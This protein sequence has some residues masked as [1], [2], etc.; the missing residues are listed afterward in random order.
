MKTARRVSIVCAVIFIGISLLSTSG[1]TA[2]FAA[3]KEM[4]AAAIKEGEVSWLDAIVVPSSAKAIAE[5]FKKEYGLPDT[6]NVKHERLASGPIATRVAEEVKANR[7][8]IDLFAAPVPTLYFDLKEYGALLRYDCPE[9]KNFSRATK[10]GLFNEPGYWQSAIAQVFA[11]VTNPKIYPKKI[12]SWNDLLSPDL[13]GGKITLPAIA[14]GGG[15]LYC[16]VG[17][18]KVLSKGYFQDMYKQKVAFDRG[19]SVDATQQLTQ[20]QILVAITSAFRI[21]QTGEQTGVE[22]TAHYPKEGV[23]LLGHPYGILAK[24][25]HPNAAK[26]LV[27]FLFSEK[28]N[29]LFIEQEGVIA[30]RDGM[31]VPEKI[32]KYSPP[33][34]E[35]V[36][37]PMDWKSL[38]SKTLNQFLEEFKEIFK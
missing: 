27:D 12:A 19:S 6:F 3:S 18:R 1:P 23:S 14:N 29:R 25:P 9:Y 33:L 30:V 17:W 38:D 24:A 28:G 7:V 10:V 16:Y 21:V 4:I 34:E 8:T 37:I 5:A 32:R 11:P 22:L 13:A 31:K 26:L 20:G 2:A 36:A 15:P 35:I